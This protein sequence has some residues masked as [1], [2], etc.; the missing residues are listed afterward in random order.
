[1]AQDNVSGVELDPELMKEARKL[2]MKFFKEMRVY[3][4]VPRATHR[5]KGGQI[6]GVRWVDV[7]KGDSE[8]PDYRSRLVGQ[9]FA[10]RRT[11]TCTHQLR[12]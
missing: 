1:M 9:E 5:M 11:T 12:L 4:R 6:I 2:E 8:K 3:T 10:P 7:N